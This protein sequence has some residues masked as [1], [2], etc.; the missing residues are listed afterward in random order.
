[1]AQTSLKQTLYPNI[2]KLI[3][4]EEFDELNQAFSLAY[5]QL[6]KASKEK[7]GLKTPKE[8]RKAM[9]AL[10]K[11]IE[12]LKELLKVK[13]KLQEIAAKQEKKGMK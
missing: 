11:V 12:L 1:M 3:D 5:Q 7:K 6:E 9:H 4:S 2:E 8:A 13:Y 10:E